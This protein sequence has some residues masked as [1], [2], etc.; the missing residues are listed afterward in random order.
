MINLENASVEQVE[1]LQAFIN[2]ESF[3]VMASAGTGKSSTLQFIAKYSPS[4]KI[5]YI[6]FDKAGADDAKIKFPKNVKATTANSLGYHHIVTPET[7]ELLVPDISIYEMANISGA[8]V[9]FRK[10]DIKGRNKFGMSIKKALNNYYISTDIELQLKHVSVAWPLEY[11][12]KILTYCKNY[13]ALAQ[14]LKCKFTHDVYMK[15]FA[16]SNPKFDHLYDAIFYDEAQDADPTMVNIVNSQKCQLVVVGDPYQQIYSFRGAVNALEKFNT[17]TSYKLSQSYRY[18]IQ[19]AN[20]ANRILEYHHNALVDIRGNRLNDTKVSITA[21]LLKEG[22]AKTIITRNNA[23][24]LKLILEAF[25]NGDK[26]YAYLD[27]AEIKSIIQSI[28]LLKRNKEP[29]HHSMIGFEDY[30][31]FLSFLGTGGDPALRTYTFLYKKYGYSTIME[32]IKNI[33]SPNVLLKSNTQ[34]LDYIFISAHKSKG[35]E[36]A[37]VYLAD[38][39]S[40][41]ECKKYNP[42]EGNLIYVSATRA[43]NSLDISEN[44]QLKKI[45][46]HKGLSSNIDSQ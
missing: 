32:A 36:F 5:L 27:K 41:L 6:V 22:Y 33:E 14:K 4:K 23:T 12:K 37:N 16:L 15:L 42:E 10:M 25:G 8:Y 29:T 30:S 7:R 44:T 39:F 45:Y 13:W 43:L 2:G 11:R 40:D 46:H 21:P 28:Y 9:E 17:E 26:Y 38:D 31:T 20:M 18:G 24:L 35:R 34:H 1:I 3:S 19:V